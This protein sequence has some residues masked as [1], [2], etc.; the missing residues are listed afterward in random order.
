MRH[1]DELELDPKRTKLDVSMATF[2]TEKVNI[3]LFIGKT[4]KKKKKKEWRTVMT[5]SSSL[6]QNARNS[7]LDTTVSLL[8]ANVT[9]AWPV[10]CRMTLRANLAF[11]KQNYDNRK[12]QFVSIYSKYVTLVCDPI[13]G[14]NKHK[15]KQMTS[16]LSPANYMYKIIHL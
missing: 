14:L 1:H 3:I 5:L 16:H 12:R 9:P 13:Q 11:H 7:T 4:R 15:Q 2:R 6:I 8:S 10:P